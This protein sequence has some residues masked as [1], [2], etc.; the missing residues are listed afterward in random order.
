MTT[1]A[2]ISCLFWFLE[3]T[4]GA[5]AMTCTWPPEARKGREWTLLLMLIS[6]ICPAELQ[7]I[8]LGCF[9]PLN[10]WSFVAAALGNSHPRRASGAQRALRK[11]VVSA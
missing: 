7:R 5:R 6:D 1:E 11:A 3:V 4:K 8:K 9:K 2:I 10:V